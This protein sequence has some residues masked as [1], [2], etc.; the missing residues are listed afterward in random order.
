MVLIFDILLNMDTI[1]TV[2]GNLDL[3]EKA[4]EVYKSLLKLSRGSAQSLSVATKIKRTTIYSILDELKDKGLIAETPG[5]SKS[6]YR[7]LS[8]RFLFEREKRK[9]QHVAK[10]IP[11]IEAQLTGNGVEDKPRVLYFKGVNGIKDLT[12]YRKQELANQTLTGFWATTE[13]EILDQFG[14]HFHKISK[15]FN[16]LRVFERGIA[17]DAPEIS[18]Y[19]E[20]YNE[21]TSDL[22]EKKILPQKIYNPE[23][24]FEFSDQW[25]KIYDFTNLQ[26]LVI[27][28]KNAAQAMNQIFELA[29]R[30]ATIVLQEEISNKD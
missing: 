28:S 26:G 9:L 22:V 10:A 25:L 18:E 30:G 1:D 19:N 4:V 7:P 16:K 24:S 14:D 13:Q 20:M 8:P 2:L 3:S 27:E 11:E 12:E 6:L 21:H 15:D 5:Q 17:T 23:V 29:W